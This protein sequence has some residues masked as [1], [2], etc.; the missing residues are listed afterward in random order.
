LSLKRGE[1]PTVIGPDTQTAQ[2]MVNLLDTG[3]G[4]VILHHAISAWPGWEGWAEVTGAR[5]LYRPGTLRGE[6]LP[7]SG[8]RMDTFTVRV[9]DPSHPITRTLF[10]TVSH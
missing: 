7:S 8:Y 10:R 5:F 9:T 1:E 2:D 6:N 3:Q 4:L